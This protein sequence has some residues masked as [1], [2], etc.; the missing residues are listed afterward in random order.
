MFFQ[1]KRLP[2]TD[3]SMHAYSCKKE[4]NM[5]ILNSLHLCPRKIDDT[6]QEEN[7]MLSYRD[8]PNLAA[9]SP[10]QRR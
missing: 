9:S 2:H 1:R 4:I 5:K 3:C 8:G 6:H 7:K 10:L